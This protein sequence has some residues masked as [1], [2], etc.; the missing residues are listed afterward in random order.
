L[1]PCGWADECFKYEVE[2]AR[3]GRDLARNEKIGRV[4]EMGRMAK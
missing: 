2:I 1:V 3:R 4:D